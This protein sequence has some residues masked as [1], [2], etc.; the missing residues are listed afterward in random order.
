VSVHIGHILESIDNDRLP[1]V[2]VS[3][4]VAG[5]VNH[6]LLQWDFFVARTGVRTNTQPITEVPRSKIGHDAPAFTDD[7]YNHILIEPKLIDVGNLASNQ[8]HVINIFNG[9]FTQKTLSGI[10]QSNST[11]INASG[12]TFPSVF[13]ALG[14]KQLALSVT[15]EG[16][17]T[18]D[19]AYLF[20]WL[21]PSDDAEAYVRGVRLVSLP[22]Q[23]EAPWSETLEWLTV[24]ITANNGF[25][26]RRRLRTSPRQSYSGSYSIPPS[27][28]ARAFNLTQGWKF[29]IWGVPIWSEVQILGTV[30]SGQTDIP[31]QVGTSDLREG[32]LVVVWEG[33]N[34]MEILEILTI[35]TASITL[36]VGVA[37]N[38]SRP[39]L[40]PVRSAYVDG[41]ISRKTSGSYSMLNINFKVNDN[42]SLPE[43][44]PQQYKG[45]DIY[46]DN[47]LLTGEYVTDS[48]TSRDDILDY[49]TGLTSRSMPWTHSKQARTIRLRRQGLPATWELRKFLHRRA[50]KLRPFWT[51]TFEDNMVKVSTGLIISSIDVRSPGYASLVPYRSDIAIQLKNGSWLARGVNGIETLSGGDLRLSLDIPINVES[52]TVDKVSYLTLQRL[53]TDRVEIHWPGNAVAECSLPILEILG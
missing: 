14:S 21:T 44:A 41:N 3:V 18:I 24:L 4:E 16:P 10:A 51:P 6:N 28:L 38:Y 8:V 43:V 40:C 19:A 42:I 32:G 49:S 36:K 17:A 34:S 23:A 39:L 30:A 31:C 20:N 45:N 9:Y 5:T 2:S 47:S 37:A 22:Y 29:R 12:L 53:D 7:F 46:F 27:E 48:V 13:G 26:Q 33:N 52:D 25:E 1:G 11:G 50:G 35:G 15:T